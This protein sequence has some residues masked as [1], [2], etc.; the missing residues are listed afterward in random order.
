MTVPMIASYA[1]AEAVFAKARNPEKGKP[2][3]NTYRLI[4]DGDEF[5]VRSS[6]KNVAKIYRNNTVEVF[7]PKNTPSYLLCYRS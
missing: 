1:D 3:K 7:V 2:L 5:I 6:N 4:K